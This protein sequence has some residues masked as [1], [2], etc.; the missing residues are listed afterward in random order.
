MLQAKNLTKEFN[1]RKALDNL[2]LSVRKGEIYC[3]LGQNG[4]GKTTTINIFLGFLDATSGEALINGSEVKT[5]RAATNRMIAYIPEVVQLYGNLSGIEN[6]DF[7]SRL[8]GFSYSEAELR[9]FLTKSGLQE[10]AQ[11]RRLSTYSKG[12]RQKVGIAIALSK[13]ADVI[14]MDEPTSGLDPK[15]TAEFTELCKAFV[16]EGKSIFMATHDIFN[17]VNVGTRI[18]IMRE[19]VLVHEL[20]THDINANQLQQ[21]YLETI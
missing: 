3:L 19:G 5:N 17:A 20:T 11:T 12:M 13:K 2:N 9:V 10:E 15:A 7:F 8:A 4:A 6:L 14:F 21:L 18:G 16:A 1:G